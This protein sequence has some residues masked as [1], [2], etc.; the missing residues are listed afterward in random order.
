MFSNNKISNLV[1]ALATAFACVEA[2]H[3]DNTNGVFDSF[4]FDEVKFKTRTNC[5]LDKYPEIRSWLDSDAAQFTQTPILVASD[6]MSRLELF[7][8]GVLIDTVH[9]YRY[10]KEQLNNLLV[11][12]GQPRDKSMTWEKINA[13]Q[14]FDRMLNN[15]GAYSEII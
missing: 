3:L 4:S 10:S 15:W 9:V 12:M 1:A 7:K 11:E 6:G 8:E 13:M 14:S 5:S 2:S